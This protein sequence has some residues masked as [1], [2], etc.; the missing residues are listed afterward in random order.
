[1][2]PTAFPRQPTMMEAWKLAT[3]TS[4]PHN[5]AMSERDSYERTPSLQMAL[6]AFTHARM[7]RHT[8]CTT[9]QR[10]I[11]ID[12]RDTAD[13][14]EKMMLIPTILFDNQIARCSAASPSS[15]ALRF[16]MD[17]IK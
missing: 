10:A 6:A 15:N 9:T 1:M 17:Y 4:A 8:L 12:A 3:R 7:Y 11:V 13:E 14:E 5:F 2:M 16:K